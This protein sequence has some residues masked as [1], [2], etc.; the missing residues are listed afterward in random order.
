M[1]NGA[2]EERVGGFIKDEFISRDSNL[3]GTLAMANIG[4]KDTGGS[5]F[6]VNVKDNPH[7]DWFSEGESQHPV[8]GRII[9]GFG[10]CMSISRVR[11][12]SKGALSERTADADNPMD[13]IK[14]LSVTVSGFTAT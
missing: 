9:D 13:A 1:K 2:N 11:T 12:A 10:I 8:F 6:F 3:Q 14:V 5:Q 7:L 4:K